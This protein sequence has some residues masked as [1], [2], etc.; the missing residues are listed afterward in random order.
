MSPQARETKAKKKNKQT[1]EWDLIK[2]KKLLHSEETIKKKKNE[3][4]PY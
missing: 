3:K 2:L 4:T 1:N